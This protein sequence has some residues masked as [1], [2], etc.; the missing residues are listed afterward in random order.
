[1]SGRIVHIERVAQGP[2]ACEM[3]VIWSRLSPS[4][5]DSFFPM[6]VTPDTRIASAIH[7]NLQ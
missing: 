3:L 2:I 4:G 6:R 7:R 1:M 5:T